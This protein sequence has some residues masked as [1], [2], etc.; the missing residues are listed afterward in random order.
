MGSEWGANNINFQLLLNDLYFRLFYRS[1]DTK[2]AVFGL[3]PTENI[4]SPFHIE[5]IEN[6]FR[7]TRDRLL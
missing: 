2:I 6:I 4:G 7:G 5:L 1:N 3:N